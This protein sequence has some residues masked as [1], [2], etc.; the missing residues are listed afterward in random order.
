LHT[1][2]KG[3]NNLIEGLIHSKTCLKVL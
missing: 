3:K 2:T 1:Q